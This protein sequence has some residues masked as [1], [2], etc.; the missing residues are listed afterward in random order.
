MRS[1]SSKPRV[2]AFPKYEG[3]VKLLGFPSIK[4]GMTRVI[5]REDNERSHVKNIQRIAAV[6]ILETPPVV[7]FGIRTYQMTPYGMKILADVMTNSPSKH[8]KK[9]KRFPKFEN[10]DEQLKKMEETLDD[11]YEIR[12]LVHTQ[13]DLTGAGRKKPEIFEIAIGASDAKAAFEW[14]KDK[15]G[16][17]M[18]VED[19]TKEGSFIDVIGITKGKGFQGVIKRHGATKL[20]HKT[21]DGARKVGSI[22][23]WTPA[24]LRWV[25][26]RYGQMGYGRRTEFNKRVMKLGVDGKEVN[27]DG[28]FLR[29]GNVKNRFVVVT[30]SV[31]GPKK[32]TVFLRQGMRAHMRKESDPQ[33]THIS[34][35]SQQR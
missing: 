4:A 5:Y 18:Q 17:E 19:F 30:G 1:S 31:P 13:P 35:V 20:S 10:L 6:T 34:L 12:A 29:Y 21:K 3:D 11:V 16:S 2:R 9:V 15:L 25:I 33:I 27:P 7:L 32:R 24:R 8:L 28:G 22:G 26:P 23:P 14:A